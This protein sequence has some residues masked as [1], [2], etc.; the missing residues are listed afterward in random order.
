MAVLLKSLW[1]KVVR[2]KL[3]LTEGITLLTSFASTHTPMAVAKAEHR[4]FL[5][6]GNVSSSID[7]CQSI[8]VFPD[9]LQLCIHSVK[10][11]EPKP[12]LQSMNLTTV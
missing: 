4:F 6:K 10:D 9:I 2:D 5:T 12:S 3:K 1:G 7:T 8:F 11:V